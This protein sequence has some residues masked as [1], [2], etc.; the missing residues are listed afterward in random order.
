MAPELFA[1]SSPSS[2]FSPLSYGAEVDIWAFGA[3]VYELATGLPPNAAGGVP[4][5]RPGRVVESGVPRLERGK[6]SEGLRGMVG[7]CLVENP[8]ARPGIEEVQLQPYIYNTSE[9][10]PTATLVELIECFRVW[11]EAGGSRASLFMAGGAEGVSEAAFDAADADDGE[12]DFSSAGRFEG[13]TLRG[14]TTT[15]D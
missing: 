9:R 10:Y 6:Y 7:F 4:Y 3:V 14:P 12:W 5:R 15:Q 2:P 11:E 1:S 8:S 13:D